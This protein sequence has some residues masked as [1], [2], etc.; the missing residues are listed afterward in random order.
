MTQADLIYK[1]GTQKT[2]GIILINPYQLTVVDTCVYNRGIETTPSNE[3]KFYF[4][5]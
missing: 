2:F 5:N 1:N 4:S 3:N